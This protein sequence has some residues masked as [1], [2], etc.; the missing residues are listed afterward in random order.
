MKEALSALQVVVVSLSS[1]TFLKRL[2][3]TL[4]SSGILYS[5][6]DV[7]SVIQSGTKCGSVD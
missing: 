5:L 7:H 3:D 6:W 2:C 4:K 1:S